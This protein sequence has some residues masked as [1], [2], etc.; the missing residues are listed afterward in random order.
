MIVVDY[1]KH[2]VKDPNIRFGRPV[3]RGTRIAVSDILGHL[4]AGDEISDVLEAFPQLTRE[5]VQAC[6]G[7]LADRDH[8]LHSA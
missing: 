2:I 8:L 1:R 5:D 4:A 7:F 6:F 3:I